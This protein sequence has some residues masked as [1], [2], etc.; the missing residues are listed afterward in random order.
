M[1]VLGVPDPM[2]LYLLTI[3]LR[4]GKEISGEYDWT[5]C[6]E[7]IGKAMDQ[8]GFLSMTIDDLPAVPSQE[9][10]RH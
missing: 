4:N 5:Q 3:K 6:L 10:G 2:K 8:E 1:A 7:R 9:R